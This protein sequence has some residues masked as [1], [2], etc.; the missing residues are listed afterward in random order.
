MKLLLLTRYGRLGSSS[1]MRI[2]Q[3]IPWFESNGITCEY[4]LFIDDKM[5]EWK[6][7][8]NSYR[9]IS[10]LIAYY[11]RIKIMLKAH[12]FNLVFIEKESLPFF[13]AIIEKILLHGVPYIL[14]YDDAVFHNY[15]L[16]ASAYIR[17][18]YSRTIDKAMAN[19]NLVIAGN[20][21]IA[22]HAIDAGT[23]HVVII[24]T[25]IDLNKYNLKCTYNTNSNLFKIV[26]IGS[27]STSHYLDLIREP[28]I[29]INQK[30][31][32][33]LRI[34]GGNSYSI[35]N[36]NIDQYI[37]SESTEA[38]L[39]KECDIG[40]MPLYNTPW[41]YGKCGYKLIQYMACG[42]PVVASP[43]GVNREIVRNGING[44][45]ADDSDSWFEALS[46]LINSIETRKK[47]GEAGR[48]QVEEKYC[49]QR[50]A[51]KLIN[52]LFDTIS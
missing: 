28:L 33:Q 7:K 29:R 1:R 27:S 30:Y 41:E 25:V 10:L 21:Y 13:S 19:A 46:L 48:K 38:D 34:I 36:I 6:Y 24:P 4:S 5:L 43:I 3:F 31:N 50:I 47:M 22:Q 20:R 35:P 52:L 12:H 51:P 32:I 16:S 17:F 40:I 14:D 42:L 45:L 37:W 15:D 8:H 39:I 11:R 9:F 18:L 2:L 23:S 44:Y 49:I 26:W